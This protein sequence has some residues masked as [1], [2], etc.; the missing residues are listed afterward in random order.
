MA[1]TPS[2]GSV[3]TRS[4]QSRLAAARA[5]AAAREEPL[6]RYLA[7]LAGTSFAAGPTANVLNGGVHADNDV[8][9]QE[10]MLAPFGRQCF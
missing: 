10:F 3:Q 7:A 6:W 8:D 1:P 9:F 5:A 4:S 2:H